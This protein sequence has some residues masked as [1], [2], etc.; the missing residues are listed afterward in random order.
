MNRSLLVIGTVFAA[1]VLWLSMIAV[2]DVRYESTRIEP[3]VYGPPE[4]V[5]VSHNLLRCTFRGECV[6]YSRIR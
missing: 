4:R 2:S 5:L 6:S 1:G 3:G